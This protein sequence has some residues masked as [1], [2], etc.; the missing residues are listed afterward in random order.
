MESPVKKPTGPHCIHMDHIDGTLDTKPKH[1][2]TQTSSSIPV[3]TPGFF[4]RCHWLFSTVQEHL[5]LG[6]GDSS[7]QPGLARLLYVKGVSKV[8]KSVKGRERKQ[9]HRHFWPQIYQPLLSPTS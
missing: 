9:V 8:E 2:A 1:K 5:S 3:D 4:D 7:K 6:Q